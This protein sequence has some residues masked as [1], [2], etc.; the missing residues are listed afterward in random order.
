MTGNKIVDKIAKVS[1]TFPQ[2]ISETV[3]NDAENI[4]FDREIRK[5]RYVSPG[6]RQNV[7]DDLRLM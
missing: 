3:T 6:K 7:I 2:N 1:R 5:E 4:E